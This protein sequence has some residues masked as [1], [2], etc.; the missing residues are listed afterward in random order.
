[1]EVSSDRGDNVLFAQ[2]SE[3]KETSEFEESSGAALSQVK[4]SLR[5]HIEFWGSIGTPRYI[6]SVI[7]KGYR[8]PFRQT[9]PG[10]TS[11]N[12]R[13]SFRVC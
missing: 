9:P 11:R 6:L 5:R 12:N 1:M 13:S 8:L 4:G 7:C 3:V 10:Y 2:L